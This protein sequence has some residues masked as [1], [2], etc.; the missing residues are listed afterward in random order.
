MSQPE[1]KSKRAQRYPK[2]GLVWYR[3]LGTDVDPPTEG[4]GS[5]LNVSRSGVGFIAS[6]SVSV[7][8]LLLVHI[9]N[10]GLQVTGLMRVARVRALEA[11]EWEV[12]V[13]IEAIPPDH[14]AILE[15]L[16][17]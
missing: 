1:G 14:R 15:E 4:L 9:R 8:D 2:P 13:H 16:F 5:S 7:G 12:G 3:I 10:R 6:T 17:R 11:G